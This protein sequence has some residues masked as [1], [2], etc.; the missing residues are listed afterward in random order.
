MRWA[1]FS[2]IRDRRERSLASLINL[3]STGR[4]KMNIIITVTIKP[5]DSFSMLTLTTTLQYRKTSTHVRYRY[6]RRPFTINHTQD[7][8]NKTTQSSPTRPLSGA[9]NQHRA[10]ILPKKLNKLGQ[11]IHAKP[12]VVLVWLAETPELAHLNRLP[13]RQP[14]LSLHL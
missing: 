12:C 9:P 13:C 10:Q 11:F 4:R 14:V 7:S 2:S 6:D 5:S 1:H 8:F 3:L